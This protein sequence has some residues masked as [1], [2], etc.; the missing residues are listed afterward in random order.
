MKF[1]KWLK[2]LT[3]KP[4]SFLEYLL[5]IILILIVDFTWCTIA[6]SFLKPYLYQVVGSYYYKSVSVVKAVILAPI[7][8]EFIFRFVPLTLSLLVFEVSRKSRKSRN[9]I[10]TAVILISS[11]IFGYF[12]YGWPSIFIQGVV[13]ALWSLFFLKVSQNAG[14]VFQGYASVVTLHGLHNLL[15]MLIS[16]L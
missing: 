9:L 4:S 10:L 8:E 1:Q 12:H 15:V 13:G 5:W 6:I 11:V 14:G 7:I 2:W 3:K 16:L